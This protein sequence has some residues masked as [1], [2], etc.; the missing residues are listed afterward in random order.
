MFLAPASFCLSF[1]LIQ[2]CNK[3]KVN[4]GASASRQFKDVSGQADATVVA[5]GDK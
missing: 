5:G 4:A 2:T 3:G 1:C